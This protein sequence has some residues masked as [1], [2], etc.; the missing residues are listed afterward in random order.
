MDIKNNNK[1][2]LCI[3]LSGHV[4]PIIVSVPIHPLY[5]GRL[6][7]DVFAFVSVGRL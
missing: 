1:K 4:R 6:H 5:L 2:Y 7:R 3:P